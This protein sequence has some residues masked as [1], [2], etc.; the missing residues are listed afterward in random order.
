MLQIDSIENTLPRFT[1]PFIELE[2]GIPAETDDTGRSWV[3]AWVRVSYPDVAAGEFT[4]TEAAKRL[5]EGQEIAFLDPPILVDEDGISLPDT[6]VTG[7]PE[8]LA[9][10]S[11]WVLAT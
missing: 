10:V 7:D 3:P 11:C 9:L 8:Q 6:A 4:W 1:P 2:D 5:T